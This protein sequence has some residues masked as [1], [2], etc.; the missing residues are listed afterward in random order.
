MSANIQYLVSSM[1]VYAS[2]FGRPAARMFYSD[3]GGVCQ[4]TRWWILTQRVM[5]VYLCV[6]VCVCVC[7]VCMHK[8]RL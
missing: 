3:D 2:F 8:I 5:F 7:V 4:D 1:L 6:C